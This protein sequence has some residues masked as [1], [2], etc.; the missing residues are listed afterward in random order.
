MK[1]L[2][3]HWYLVAHRSGARIFEQEGVKQ[4]LTLLH[5]FENHD[6]SLKV[7]ELVSDRQGRSTGGNASNHTA[8][9]S[10]N[11]SSEHVL[12][13]FTHKLAEFLEQEV[14]RSSFDSLV[15]VAEPHVLG[16][17]K[18]TIGHST[19]QRFRDPL[20]KDLVHV[21]NHDMMK[22]LKDA[23]CIAEEIQK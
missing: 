5:N 8:V 4:E 2:K 7:S 19:A 13:V 17:L 11:K 15:L 9:G 18:K 6:G 12:E 3:K 20:I 21:T 14:Q 1:N 23:L 10:E 16:G 22:H